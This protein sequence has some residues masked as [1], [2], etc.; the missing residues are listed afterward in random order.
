MRWLRY[1]HSHFD[2]SPHGSEL[3]NH[4]INSPGHDAALSV[5]A[6]L[7]WFNVGLIVFGSSFAQKRPLVV[8]SETFLV[9]GQK[10]ARIGSKEADSEQCFRFYPKAFLASG[11]EPSQNRFQYAHFEHFWSQAQNLA[12]MGLRRLILSVSGTKSGTWPEQV[13]GGSF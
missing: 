12:R 4:A 8:E 1:L 5:R 3:Q 2:L 11:P 6:Q 7:F 9:Q 13:S 10:L